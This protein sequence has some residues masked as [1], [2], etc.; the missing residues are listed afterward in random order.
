MKATAELLMVTRNDRHP[1]ERADLFGTR[2][3]AAIET[4]EGVRLNEVF[5]KEATGGDKPP[6]SR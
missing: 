2:F 6:G 3:V 1:T 5:V 4:E